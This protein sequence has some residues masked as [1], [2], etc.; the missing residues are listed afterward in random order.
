MS[1]IGTVCGNLHAQDL[2]QESYGTG[3]HHFFAGKYKQAVDSFDVAINQR[4][5]DAKAYY[6]RGLAN[7]ALGDHEKAEDDFYTG[8]KFE[9]RNGSR[10]DPKVTRSLERIQGGLRLGLEKVRRQVAAGVQRP[11]PGPIVSGPVYSV[12][13]T[14]R[15]VFA[16][17]INLAP[18]SVLEKTILPV[19]H[20]EIAVSPKPAAAEVSKTN[21][22]PP[23]VVTNTPQPDDNIP[24][25]EEE[26]TLPPE[27]ETTKSAVVPEPETTEI[28]ET[29]PTPVGP[30][31]VVEPPKVMEEKPRTPVASTED[32]FGAP[33]KVTEEKPSAPVA[34]TD[35]FGEPAENST[36]AAVEELVR[37]IQL[38]RP[39]SP[40]VLQKVNH[41]L[42]TVTTMTHLGSLR[43]LVSN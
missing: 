32:P 41:Y 35:P 12:P 5:D 18:A 9:M 42:V 2:S 29:P 34:S 7:Y 16:G 6:Y 43:S 20:D 24:A 30:E 13:Y 1:L 22:V 36:K 31:E 39:L 10:T 19:V 27:P 17:Q 14:S 38:L 4:K 40:L 8:A 37:Q 23:E 25:I 11:S 15:N 33:A 28:V 21:S 3:V 26:K